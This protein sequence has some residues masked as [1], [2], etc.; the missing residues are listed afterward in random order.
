VPCVYQSC[1][2]QLRIAGGSPNDDSFHSPVFPLVSKK[3]ASDADASWRG[4]PA[5]TLTKNALVCSV[6]YEFSLCHHGGLACALHLW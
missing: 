6:L 5:H 3:E 1:F 4:V 2:F